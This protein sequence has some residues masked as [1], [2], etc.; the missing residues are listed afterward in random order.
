M[1]HL[2]LETNGLTPPLVAIEC[3]G[4]RVWIAVG[5]MR[6]EADVPSDGTAGRAIALAAAELVSE[7]DEQQ[8]VRPEPSPAP[9]V[10]RWTLSVEG[11]GR[12][13]HESRIR[14]GGALL[15]LR[16]RVTHVLVWTLGVGVVAGNGR[17]DVG[18]VKARSTWF[19]TALGAHAGRTL[20][21]QGALGYRV[22][23]GTWTGEPNTSDVVGRSTRGSW[24]GP[25][26]RSRIGVSPGRFRLSLNVEAGYALSSAGTLAG[27]EVF[28]AQGWWLGAG[29]EVGVAIR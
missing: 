21:W 3:R 15:R 4:S 12:Y 6:R 25:F 7:W 2:E 16:Y 17:S 5:D 1:L 10:L 27:A 19:D 13:A 28:S 8:L 26:V 23:V 22:S 9:D 29:L 24:S 14:Q 20:W 18:R 11:I